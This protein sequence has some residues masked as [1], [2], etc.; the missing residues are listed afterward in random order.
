MK[1]FAPPDH[2][3]L[4]DVLEQVARLFFKAEY[5]PPLDEPEFKTYKWALFKKQVEL[6]DLP[7][8]RQVEAGDIVGLIGL[9]HSVTGDT[10]CDVRHPIVLEP[11]VFSE[12]VI[13]MAIESES[14]ADRKKLAT[15]T[16]SRSR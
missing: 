14:T 4:S 2:L 5:L 1:D 7:G 8:S 15:C 6:Y 3:F 9:R 12:T 16:E 11:I 13:S 10:L